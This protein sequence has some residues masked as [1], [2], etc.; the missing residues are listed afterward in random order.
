MKNLFKGAMASL[1]VASMAVVGCNSNKSVVADPTSIQGEWTIVEAQGVSTEGGTHP[2]TITFD[3]EG[4]V[5]GCATVNNFFG[6]YTFDGKN[7]S[8]DHLGLTRMMGMD[9]SM[10]I[11]EAVVDA[12]N[13][14][15]AAE[16][17]EGKATFF[18]AEGNK[19][20]ELKK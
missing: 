1:L 20:I 17:E 11:E 12:I 4:K 19:L 3:A 13:K 18:D 6:E 7:L 16:V 9:H 15:K 8:F 5:N 2:A 10:K 14:T